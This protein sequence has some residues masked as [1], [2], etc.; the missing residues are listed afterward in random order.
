MKTILPICNFQRTS[1]LY[2]ASLFD[3]GQDLNSLG[4]I[5]NVLGAQAIFLVSLITGNK[6]ILFGPRLPVQL[7]IES[8][9]LLSVS[10]LPQ[11]VR[12]ME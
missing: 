11:K 7:Q 10:I 4:N 9:F 5:Y 12:T 6:G 1:P 8:A 2:K 3:G